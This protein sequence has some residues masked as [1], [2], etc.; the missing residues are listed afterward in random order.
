MEKKMDFVAQPIGR[1]RLGDYLL[2][3]LQDEQ[4]S[5]FRASVAFVK[6][7]GVKHIYSLLSD[8]QQRGK[9]KISV[10]IDNGVT[11]YEGLVNLLDAIGTDSEM[12]IFHNENSST[13]H[14][15]VYLFAND[16]VA[17]FIVGSG[18]LTEGGL[19]TNYEAFLR[20]SL[21]LQNAEDRH[22]YDEIISYLDYWADPST[23]C[24]IQASLPFLNDLR[25]ND[26]LPTENQIRQARKEKSRQ[27]Q[28]RGK[29]AKGFKPFKMTKVP[30]AP[31]QPA[32]PVQLPEGISVA[33]TTPDTFVV[34]PVEEQDGLFMGF[35][36][37]LQQT[38]VGY[39]QKT[40]GASR[41]SPEIFI[42]LKARDEDP[43]FWGWR[44]LFVQ[45]PKN[46][47]KYDRWNVKMLIRGNIESI[48]MMTWP[49]KHD[50]RLRSES[51]RR[52][53]SPGDI[54]KIERSDGTAGYQ[55]VVEVISSTGPNYPAHLALCSHDTPN[56][57]KKWGYY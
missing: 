32:I 22:Q 31:Y 46:L 52:G 2:G 57:K 29:R 28:E 16:Q 12:W 45:D 15:K 26:Y 36:M 39:G 49:L 5:L 21:D 48:N 18:N 56:S 4:W 9:A 34:E 37:T 33:E 10:G 25:D 23:G 40:A 19:F 1:F 14:P 47:D 20:V 54:L 24:S 41:R 42:P 53:A 6:N 3:N 11:T 38:D 55:Y 35:V 27:A 13:F 7:S 43:I 50:F 8:F 17:D 51:L 44:A 30:P